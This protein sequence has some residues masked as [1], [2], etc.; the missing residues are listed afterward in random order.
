MPTP[1]GVHSGKHKHTHPLN[2]GIRSTASTQHPLTASSATSRSS[3]VLI[4]LEYGLPKFNVKFKVKG[5]KDIF[6]LG[7]DF[8]LIL[9]DD[10]FG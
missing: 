7:L 6:D 10:E 1:F 9:D 5:F 2:S 4:F 3:T 8:I